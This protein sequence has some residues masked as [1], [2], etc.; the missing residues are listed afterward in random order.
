MAIVF[1][2]PV[3]PD[4][5]SAFVRNV[6]VPSNLGL[7]NAF[8]TR[9]NLTNTVNFAEI[10]KRNRT[11]RYR[12]Y[13]GRIHVSDRD[14]G[15]TGSVGMIPLSDSRNKG[16]YERL[17]LEFA[18]VNGTNTAA[19]ADAIYN[20]A[21]DLTGNIYRRLELAWGDV[22]TD[23]K[24]TV[25]EINGGFEADFGVP[26]GHLV[27]AGTL[28]SNVATATVLTNLITWHDVYVATNGAPAG[29]IRTSSAVLRLVQRNK[30]IIDA[31]YGANTG[32]TVVTLD[33]VNG[34]L[35]GHGLPPFV[36]PY[37]TQVESVAP[38]ANNALA[39]VIPANRVLFT[40]AELGDLGRTEWGVTATA[41]ELVNSNL[42]E[43]SFQEA[44]GIAGV[45][46][47]VGPPY[48]EF[49]FVDAVAFPVLSDAKRL[50]VATVT[51]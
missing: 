31:V 47:K 45:V 12:T 21:E 41:L 38:D 4:A 26:A 11:A 20:D 1:D 32:K 8:P 44:P 18:R 25:S 51:A 27:T 24:L 16:E 22:L 42:A 29:A 10:V 17:Q 19:L 49:T 13:D 2:A 35:A 46:E 15:S 40:P 34:L 5:L 36:A 43:M 50:F 14:T 3:S 28:W 6:P 33:E 7:L 48:R 39:R 30:E 23:G 9:N 37:D